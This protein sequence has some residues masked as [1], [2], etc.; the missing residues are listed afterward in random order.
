MLERLHTQQRQS[1]SQSFKAKIVRTLYCLLLSAE[2]C[3]SIEVALPFIPSDM[4]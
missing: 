3:R 4:R 2:L 1:I